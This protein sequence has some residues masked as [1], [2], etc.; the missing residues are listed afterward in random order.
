[1]VSMH[2]A[3]SFSFQYTDILN[4]RKWFGLWVAVFA[5]LIMGAWTR[6]QVD[7]MRLAGTLY[8]DGDETAFWVLACWIFSQWTGC[9]HCI[10]MFH[11]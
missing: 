6:E 7:Q 11:L 4:S 10:G 1:M 8:V 5:V 2:R 3:K 9:F